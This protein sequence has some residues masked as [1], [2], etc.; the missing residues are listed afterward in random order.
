MLPPG[1]SE[2]LDARLAAGALARGRI[3]AAQLDA[4]RR[5][6]AAEPSPAPPLG[7]LL[8][9]LGFLTIADVAEL[10][11]AVS[12]APGSAEA[13]WADAWRLARRVAGAV[14]LTAPQALCALREAA[15]RAAAA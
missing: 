8:C 4:A 14:R 10:H 6:Q 7:V 3:T 11:D 13:A 12:P 2:L 9:E 5:A 1:H 15:R